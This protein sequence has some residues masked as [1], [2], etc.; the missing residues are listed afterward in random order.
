MYT[1]YNHHILFTY[2]AIQR[3]PPAPLYEQFIRHIPIAFLVNLWYN[4]QL[5]LRRTGTNGV[6]RS[7]NMS[8]HAPKPHSRGGKKPP[9]VRR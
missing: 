5:A 3:V 2:G 1:L 7:T 4:V 6:A 9:K 8:Y